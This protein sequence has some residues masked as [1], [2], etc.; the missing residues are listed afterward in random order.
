M[1]E[2]ERLADMEGGET[3]LAGETELLTG[4]RDR[5]WKY[6]GDTETMRIDDNLINP[7]AQGGSKRGRGRGRGR[8]RKNW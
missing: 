6:V 7:R 3:D 4:D 1:G 8:R 2:E 5:S